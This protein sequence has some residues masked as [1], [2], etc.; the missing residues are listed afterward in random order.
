MN[1]FTTVQNNS[2]GSTFLDNNVCHGSIG[3]NL[4][5]LIFT[6][7]THSLSNGAHATN[8]VTPGTFFAIHLTKHMVK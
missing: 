7:L 2:F 6:G 1:G 8:S 3:G 5:A 4:D